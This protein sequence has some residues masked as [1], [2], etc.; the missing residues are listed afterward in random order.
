MDWSA[1]IDFQKVFDP[2]L[3]IAVEAKLKPD[4]MIER[5]FGFTDLDINEA[6]VSPWE[7]EYQVIE[8]KFTEKEYGD[9]VPQIIF[10]NLR[11]SVTVPQIEARKGATVVDEYSKKFINILLVEDGDLNPETVM[12]AAIH[13]KGIRN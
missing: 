12:E 4:E 9:V 7:T 13:V 8:R 2:I 3:G 11:D 5:L 1:S 10:L 6:S